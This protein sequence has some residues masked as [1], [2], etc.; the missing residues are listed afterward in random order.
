MANRRDEIVLAFSVRGRSSVIQEADGN[1][2]DVSASHFVL[3]APC[4]V[5]PVFCLVG[6]AWGRLSALDG[7]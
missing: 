5:T 7:L 3:K 6:S 4:V 1:K 2:W